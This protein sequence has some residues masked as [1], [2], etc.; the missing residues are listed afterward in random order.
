MKKHE[1]TRKTA[2]FTET[3]PLGVKTAK[4]RKTPFFDKNYLLGKPPKGV[5]NR[6]KKEFLRG[7]PFREKST[8]FMFFGKNN[9]FFYYTRIFLYS[10]ANNKIN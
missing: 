2:F 8:F 7:G 10:V 6:S 4:T 5:Q 3:A 9:L 1:K